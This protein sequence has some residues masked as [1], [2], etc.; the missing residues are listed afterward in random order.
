MAGCS[1]GGRQ[2]G[3]PQGKG[4]DARGRSVG[5]VRRRSRG[6]RTG[7]Y[8]QE[9][10]RAGERVSTWRGAPVTPGCPQGRTRVSRP[11]LAAEWP[12]ANAGISGPARAALRGTSAP[13]G[14]AP[15][16]DDKYMTAWLVS[17]SRMRRRLNGL[18]MDVRFAVRTRG[19]RYLDCGV[20]LCRL[21]VCGV[22]RPD[23]PAPAE[24]LQEVRRASEALE[25]Y[26]TTITTVRDEPRVRDPEYRDLDRSLDELVEYM[27][28]WRVRGAN[29]DQDFFEQV[30]RVV[31]KAGLAR[32][33]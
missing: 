11:G 15:A 12:A 18:M 17:M 29:P 24:Y 20:M 19:V 21:H 14:K 6:A 16:P 23:S 25:E 28:A 27:R 4:R 33:S 31:H 1:S 9:C 2:A 10:Y 8:P 30:D 3:Q 32:L 13:P 22:I 5:S 7:S 26:V